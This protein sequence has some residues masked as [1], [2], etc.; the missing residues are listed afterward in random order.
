MKLLRALVLLGFIAAFRAVDINLPAPVSAVVRLAT[1]PLAAV[2]WFAGTLELQEDLR[3]LLTMLVGFPLLVLYWFAI[4][5][6]LSGRTER[7]PR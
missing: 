4:L 1:L 6:A 7:G 3:I 5:A 2:R